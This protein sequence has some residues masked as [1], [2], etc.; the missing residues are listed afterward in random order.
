MIGA[1]IQARMSSR[2]LRG[3]SLADICGKPLLQYLIEGLAQCRTLDSLAVATSSEPGDDAI[4]ALARS[5]GIVCLRGPLDNVAERFALT[6]KQLGL[7]VF[8]RVC[9]DSPLLDWRL[10]DQA[11]GMLLDCNAD[12][13]TNCHPRVF[14][15]G[16][17]VEVMRSEVFLR[18]LPDM[19]DAGDQEHV[20]SYFHARPEAFKIVAMGAD[21][22]YSGLS[23]CVDQAQDLERIRALVRCLKRPH[24]SYTLA[25]LYALAQGLAGPCAPEGEER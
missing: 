10:V 16:A 1:I 20:T 17:S 8:V 5:L 12:M 21:R 2:R 4:A 24:W 25:E 14:P 7:K 15:P 13:V 6:I 11:I 19:V 22:E 3:K 18:A 23:L 9:G